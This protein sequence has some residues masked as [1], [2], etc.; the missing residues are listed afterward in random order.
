MV[1][2]DKRMW[3]MAAILISGMALVGCSKSK[4]TDS[5]TGGTSG[6]SSGSTTT[7][8]AGNQAILGN[9]GNNATV[10]NVM[11]DTACE[12][13][14]KTC[15]RCAATDP[16][17]GIGGLF[18][19]GASG[20]SGGGSGTGAGRGFMI[21]SLAATC[22]A[23]PATKTC[24]TMS[25]GMCM[26]PPET[27]PK[28]PS[29]FGPGCCIKDMNLCGLD[30]SLFGMGCVEL[31]TIKRMFGALVAGRGI[32]FPDSTYCDTGMPVPQPDGGAAGASGTGAGGASGS[33]SSGHGN[34]DAGI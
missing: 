34:E 30:A 24:G 32:M 16:N 2:M 18:M 11:C 4:S 13:S 7:N 6:G 12:T 15:F 8:T 28:C 29:P 21:P 10:M 5:G 33:G 1:V 19:M 27:A 3:C 14:P 22:C 26:A 17:S 31:G 9:G 25:N 23:D 20:T